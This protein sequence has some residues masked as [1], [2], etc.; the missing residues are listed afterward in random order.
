[1]SA[2]KAGGYYQH[3]QTTVSKIFNHLA[4]Y[5]TQGQ[6]LRTANKKMRKQPKIHAQFMAQVINKAEV[7]AHTSLLSKW[8][9]VKNDDVEYWQKKAQ[10]LRRRGKGAPTKG[11]GKRAKNKKK[12]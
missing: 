7:N 6:Y 5:Q 12:K 3:V 9:M 4:N 2:S 8:G 11:E 1:M 10:S